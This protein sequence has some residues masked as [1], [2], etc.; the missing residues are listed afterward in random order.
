MEKRV[1]SFDIGNHFTGVAIIDMRP[2]RSFEL[3]TINLFEDKTS[4]KKGLMDMIET[5]IDP[6][7]RNI[8]TKVV[9]V[10]ENVFLYPNWTLQ[11]IHRK[12]RDHYQGMGVL[13]KCLL[14]SQKSSGGL[15][16]HN[17]SSGDDKTKKKTALE[18]A[19]CL[20][21]IHGTDQL[22]SQFEAFDRKH[23]V[24][25]ALLAAH[26][27][28]ENPERLYSVPKKTKTKPV[29]STNSLSVKKPRI[30]RKATTKK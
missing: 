21:T 23:D 7:V 11:R 16:T 3:V 17:I 25:D 8:P 15:A 18:C 10:L 26:Y 12:I 6:F 27:L 30:K 28:F 29:F 14:P 9:V 24:A 1:V 22:K 20:L 2:P 4:D 19:R 13:V 5:T